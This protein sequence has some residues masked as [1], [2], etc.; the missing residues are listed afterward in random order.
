MKVKFRGFR[1]TESIGK[2]SFNTPA[3][4]KFIICA[5]SFFIGLWIVCQYYDPL[6]KT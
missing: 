2:S 1:L 4:N 6:G 5:M 3:K